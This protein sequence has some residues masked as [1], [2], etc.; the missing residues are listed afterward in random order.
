MNLQIQFLTALPR[1]FLT[2]LEFRREKLL[3]GSDKDQFV[4][5]IYVEVPEDM[6]ALTDF[7]N[8]KAS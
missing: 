5:E 3:E 4:V 7:G 2:V 8:K 1:H 6:H